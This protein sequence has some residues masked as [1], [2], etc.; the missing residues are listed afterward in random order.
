MY[1]NVFVR[2]D[3]IHNLIPAILLCKGLQAANMQQ[4]DEIRVFRGEMHPLLCAVSCWMKFSAS[5]VKTATDPS[6]RALSPE[7]VRISR[8]SRL[9]RRAAVS[10]SER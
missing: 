1:S 5:R 3:R 10:W 7:R 6:P 8:P 2:L 9:V 4:V